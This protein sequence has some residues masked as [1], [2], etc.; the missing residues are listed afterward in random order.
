MS[1]DQDVSFARDVWIEFSQISAMANYQLLV[2]AVRPYLGTDARTE[3]KITIGGQMSVALGTRTAAYLTTRGKRL[4][5]GRA[6][7]TAS[8]YA[9]AHLYYWLSMTGIVRS[10][11][12]TLNSALGLV[13]PDAAAIASYFAWD[14]FR[15][16][17]NRVGFLS[18]GAVGGGLIGTFVNVILSGIDEHIDQRI[19]QSVLVGSILTG[20]GAAW[21]FTRTMPQER[22][23]A[24]RIAGSG[25]GRTSRGSSSIGIAPLISPSGWGFALSLSY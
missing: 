21:Y 17:A 15:M 11:D 9:W 10:E 22:T 12:P 16:S 19:Q 6:S 13:L 8:S 7:L 20:Q 5:P 23:S 4:S 2:E 18:V 1:K 3:E 14:H 25:T 24:S